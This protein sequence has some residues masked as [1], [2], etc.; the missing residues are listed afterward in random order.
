MVCL[1]LTI[2]YANDI[3][4][5]SHRN[6]Q[7]RSRT[8]HLHLCLSVGATNTCT[9]TNVKEVLWTLSP[10]RGGIRLAR[11]LMMTGPSHLIKVGAS[12]SD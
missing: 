3:H 2:L 1:K 8:L 9:H 5:A 6:I 4:S 12:E 7:A 10:R 11:L